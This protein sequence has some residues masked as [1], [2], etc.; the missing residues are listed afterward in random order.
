MVRIVK[1]EPHPSV[2]KEVVCLKCG[3]TLEYTPVDVKSRYV[4]DYDGGGD[5]VKWIDYLKCDNQVYVK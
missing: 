4:R 3:V 1:S 2:V 5:T